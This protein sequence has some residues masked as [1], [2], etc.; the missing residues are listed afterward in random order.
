MK[1]HILELLRNHAGY[2]SGQELC[3]QFNVSRTAVWKAVEQLKKEGYSIEA[4]RNRGYRLCENIGEVFNKAEIDAEMDT[5]YIGRN[6]YFYNVI[7][8]TNTEAKRLAE[9]GACDGT[10]L[11]ADAQTAGKGRRGRE[12]ISP[13]GANIYLTLLLKPEFQPDKAPML[14]LLMALAIAEGIKRYAEDIE[15]VKDIGI[16]WPNDIVINGKKVCGILTE[17][18]V[19]QDYIQ[20]VV[21]GAGI[22]VKKQEFSSEIAERAISLEDEFGAVFS[23]SRLVGY[24]MKAFEKHYDRFKKT[25]DMSDVRDAYEKVLVN[26][27]REVRVLDPKGEYD[28]IA[29]GINDTGELLVQLEDGSVR[30]IYAGEVSVRGIY[31]YV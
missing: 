27:G 2:V 18:G 7:G 8:S 10:L 19:E 25:T 31:G 26:K 28:G 5:K 24:I 6:S 21:I 9:E 3:E 4:V 20:Y 14:T 22:N 11:V 12:W 16:K 29:V 15:K 17:M 13:A 1:N 30:E 23:R